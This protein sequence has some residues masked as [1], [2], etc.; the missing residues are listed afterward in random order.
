MAVAQEKQRVD[1]LWNPTREHRSAR[2]ALRPPRI[3][4]EGIVLLHASVVIVAR[5]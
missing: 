3:L 5:I 1:Q 4:S 2:T